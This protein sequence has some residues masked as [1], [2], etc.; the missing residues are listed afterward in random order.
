[1]GRR[2]SHQRF[3]H[4]REILRPIWSKANRDLGFYGNPDTHFNRD[5]NFNCNRNS[6]AYGDAETFTDAE[7]RADAQVS[8]CSAASPNCT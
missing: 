6:Y 3:E 8:A 5:T 1:M 7:I 4:R 2:R